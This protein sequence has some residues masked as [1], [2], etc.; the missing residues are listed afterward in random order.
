MNRILSCLSFDLCSLPRGAKAQGL[1][2]ALRIRNGL[3]EQKEIA[4]KCKKTLAGLEDTDSQKNEKEKKKGN[5]KFGEIFSDSSGS[6]VLALT[7]EGL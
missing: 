7:M 6:L 3:L 2:A 5:I 4:K 1:F